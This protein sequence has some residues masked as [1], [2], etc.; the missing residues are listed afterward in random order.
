MTNPQQNKVQ[1]EIKQFGKDI[2]LVQ[3]KLKQLKNE[4]KLIAKTKYR[5][6]QI[7]KRNKMQIKAKQ[8]ERKINLLY[9]RVK[10]F[11]KRQLIGKVTGANRKNATSFT[12]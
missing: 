2:N 5:Q 4:K 12:K 7:T 8:I 3:D 10:Q 6:K 1:S 9:D 11:K